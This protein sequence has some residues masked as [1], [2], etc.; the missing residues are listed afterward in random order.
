M[1]RQLIRPALLTSTA[2]SRRVL[3]LLPAVPSRSNRGCPTDLL[4]VLED[5]GCTTCGTAISAG[6]PVT[7]IP[8]ICALIGAAFGLLIGYGFGW[9]RAMYEAEAMLAD[10]PAQPIVSDERAG[11]V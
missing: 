11:D 10:E 4:M 1:R 7:M 3:E 5:P 6:V 8:V 2:E 9:A